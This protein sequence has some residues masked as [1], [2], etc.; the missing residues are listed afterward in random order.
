MPN[1]AEGDLEHAMKFN[2]AWR[3]L[4]ALPD[5]E[6][7]ELWD[8]AWNAGYHAGLVAG[9]KEVQEEIDLHRP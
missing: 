1:T 2:P 4:E 9:R 3:K 7:Q 5:H 6:R 8:N